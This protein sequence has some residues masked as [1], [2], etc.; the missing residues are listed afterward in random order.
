M[1]FRDHLFGNVFEGHIK[2]AGIFR[3][4]NWED[5]SHEVKL[6]LVGRALI[7]EDGKTYARKI[8]VGLK[9]KETLDAAG[10]SY[11]FDKMKQA[12]SKRLFTLYGQPVIV[13]WYL[14]IPEE[15]RKGSR[16]AYELVMDLVTRTSAYK[17]IYAPSGLDLD[18]EQAAWECEVSE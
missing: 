18:L 17:E 9:V 6:Q 10:I 8:G 1:Y 13:G 3:L 16:P 7:Y 14:P 5:Q 4:I 11:V 12:I 2:I 15:I